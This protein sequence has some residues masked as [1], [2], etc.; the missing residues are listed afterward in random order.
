[1][2]MRNVRCP[3]YGDCLNKA[4][5]QGLDGFICDKCPHRFEEDT[6]DP[7][8]LDGARLLLWAILI[9]ARYIEAA[10]RIRR[11]GV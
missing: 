5:Y 3:R 8:E 4:I 7:A 2:P 9:P 1:M 11:L 6:I 10:I